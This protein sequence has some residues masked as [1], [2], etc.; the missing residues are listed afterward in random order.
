MLTRSGAMLQFDD[1]VRSTLRAGE[2]QFFPRKSAGR[3]E[4]PK[5]P[6]VFKSRLQAP[7]RS[8][9]GFS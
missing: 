4:S 2:R 5:L 9:S 7:S 8:R 3:V 1:R 6:T